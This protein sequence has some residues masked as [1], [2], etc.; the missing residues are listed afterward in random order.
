MNDNNNMQYFEQPPQPPIY[1]QTKLC[2]HCRSEM[3]VRATVCPAC[4]KKQSH[5]LLTVLLI[6]AAVFIGV[7][8]CVGFIHGFIGALNKSSAEPSK[9]VSESKT[10][11]KETAPITSK[12]IYNKNGVKISYTGADDNSSY[13]YI[14]LLIENDSDKKY[15]VQVDD[16]S[17][18]GYMIDPIMSVEVAPHKKCNDQIKVFKSEL[19]KNNIT[20]VNSVEFKFRIFNWDDWTDTTVSNT[21]TLS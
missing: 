8:F 4:R 17:I 9:T 6:A 13:M 7:P 5:P 12:L 1:P 14:Q 19:T 11:E 3:D 16:F 2:K 10:T 20:K 21:I 18:N 15:C